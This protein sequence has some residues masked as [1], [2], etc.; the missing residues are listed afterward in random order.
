MGRT[1]SEYR[2]RS[3]DDL[4]ARPDITARPPAEA[5]RETLARLLLDAYRD[6]ID[7]EGEDLDDARDAIDHYLGVID[8]ERSAVVVDADAAPV[9]ACFVLTVD[10]IVYIDPIIVA[11]AHQGGGLGA[12]LVADVLR[13]LAADGITEVGATVTDGNIP[14]ER[15]FARLGFERVGAWE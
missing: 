2:L 11:T 5:D 13:R 15:L 12:A 6:T 14:S 3:L 7:D 1:R 10:G 9:A 8:R 4:P